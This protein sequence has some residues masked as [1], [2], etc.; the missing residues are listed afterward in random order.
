[1]SR[2]LFNLTGDSTGNAE[3]RA[4]REHITREAALA[5]THRG[6]VLPFNPLEHSMEC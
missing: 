1:M 4:A 5:P 2:T 6:A 3:L